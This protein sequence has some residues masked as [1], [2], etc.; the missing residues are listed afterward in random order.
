MAETLRG[1]LSLAVSGFG[2]WA[3]DIGGFE[4][5]P[6]PSLYK[7]WV[8]FGLLSSHSRLHGSS[9]YRVPWIFE[10]SHPGEGDKC[11]AVLRQ[12]VK[13]KTG[14]MPYILRAALEVN[15][16]GTPIMRPMFLEFPDDFNAWGLDTQYMFG[17]DLLVAPVLSPEGWVRFY[18][19]EVTS[20]AKWRSW[21]DPSKT[22]EGGQWVRM[23]P[24]SRRLYLANV[25][26][27][28]RGNAR[29]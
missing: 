22:Y 1:G 17:G 12:A 19:P 9:S 28:V 21:F 20:E 4:G 25:F 3:H 18:V 11:S 6:E 10:E 15:H 8:Q 16:K 2:Y 23:V 7:R 13:R 24:R 5:L 27:I 14:L 29:V 26:G